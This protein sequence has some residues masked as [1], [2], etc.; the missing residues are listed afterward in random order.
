[1]CNREP[2]LPQGQEEQWLLEGCTAGVGFCLKGIGFLPCKKMFDPKT[3]GCFFPL[4]LCVHSR[5]IS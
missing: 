4:K 3:L 2:P 1:V 5:Y